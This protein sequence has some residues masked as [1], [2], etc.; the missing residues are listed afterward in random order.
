M[1]LLPRAW[2]DSA[3]PPSI[4]P[5]A[6]FKVPR[7]PLSFSCSSLSLSF[8]SAPACAAGA[9]TATQTTSAKQQPVTPST[10]MPL[11]R[12]VV[13]QDTL[14]QIPRPQHGR[15]GEAHRRRHQVPWEHCSRRSPTS[16]APSRP[17]VRH[18]T[19]LL[20]Y[21]CLVAESHAPRSIQ[22]HLQSGSYPLPSARQSPYVGPTGHTACVEDMPYHRPT[23][24]S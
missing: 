4:P 8:G 19:A 15:S 5:L 21:R 24:K 20:R 9:G 23:S 3:A 18:P 16:P 11:A 10:I 12:G 6:S 2:T 17:S 14:F 1:D 13:R 22:A 7:P